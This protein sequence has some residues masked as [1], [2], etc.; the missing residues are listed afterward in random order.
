MKHDWTDGAKKRWSR[1][2]VCAIVLFYLVVS[3]HTLFRNLYFMNLILKTK[4]TLSTEFV[5]AQVRANN[6]WRKP[7]GY[8]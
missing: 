5:L 1:L 4:Y 7:V 8:E 6:H 2:F 3:E